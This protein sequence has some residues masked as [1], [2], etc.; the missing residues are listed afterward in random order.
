[1]PRLH[2]YTFA[3]NEAVL[4]PFFL[5]HYRADLGWEKIV[6]FD[7]HSTDGTPD[8]L[9]T[10]PRVEVRT[11]GVPD[12][13]SDDLM[14]DI[15]NQAW[16]ASR[17]QADWVYTPDFDEFLYH[18]DLPG[19][20]TAVKAPI[21]QLTGYDMVTAT[22]PVPEI[23]LVSQ[24]RFGLLN[25]QYSKPTLFQPSLVY[26]IRF[27]SGAH[28]CEP[29]NDRGEVLKLYGSANAKLLHYKRLGLEYYAA[30]TAT[31]AKR[32]T[33]KPTLPPGAR[34][35]YYF[36]PAGSHVKSFRDAAANAVDVIT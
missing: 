13:M 17:G 19:F 24:C 36:A 15:R 4:V 34:R 12:R 10:D 21:V 8:L 16:K 11:Y 3:W 31:L 29:F 2:L 6:V 22:L 7:H 5:Q 23:P 28:H 14:M 27:D 20:L 18:H 32:L 1:M 9:R 25:P 33:F 30:R 35:S 26:D